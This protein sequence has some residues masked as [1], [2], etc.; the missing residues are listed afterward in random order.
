MRRGFLHVVGK[1]NEILLHLKPAANWSSYE[2]HLFEL[3]IGRLIRLG[4]R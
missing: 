4:K 1:L 3:G 2:N